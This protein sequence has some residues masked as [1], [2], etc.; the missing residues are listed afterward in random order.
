MLASMKRYAVE[1]WAP[2]YGSP[3]QAEQLEPSDARI[4]ADVEV[5]TAEWAPRRASGPTAERVVFVDGVRR[6][7]ARIWI[8]GGGDLPYPAI[9]GSYAAGLACCDGEARVEAAQVR[10]GLIG[11]APGLEALDT[12]HARY[13][14]HAVGGDTAEDLVLGL[15]Q[16]MR[17]LETLVVAQAPD[18]DLVVTDGPLSRAAGL[19]AHTIGYVKT[20]QR[21]YLPPELGRVVAAL[22]AG[23]RTPL[24]VSTTSWSRY[25]WYVKL[26]GP[27][28]HPW[29]GVVRAEASGDLGT[30]AAVRLADLS[31]ATLPAFASGAHKDPRAPQNLYPIAEL[32]RALRRR[33]GDAQL[34]YRAL[35]R[36]AA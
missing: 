30:A 17:A 3:L 23:E 11:A 27:L 33:L 31:A 25:S 18:A 22:A 7:D 10:R 6:V 24:F 15:Q 13:E 21:S 29:A 36:A 26:P 34:L 1:P 19:P 9:A 4:D 20:H 32:E 8:D 35:C 16:R 28:G 12:A 14:P 2:E 5:R